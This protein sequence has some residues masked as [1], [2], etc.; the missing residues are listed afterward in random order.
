MKIAISTDGD[1]VSPHFG[2]CPSFTIIE[3]EN[4]EVV[5]KEIIENPGHHPGFIPEFLHKIG[6]NC[7]VCGGM[8]PRAQQICSQIGITSIVGITGKIQD[9]IE[10]I[11]KGTLQS[12][13]SL[14]NPGSGKNY[15]IEKS[16][17]NHDEKKETKK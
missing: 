11:K 10:E 17:C 9:V 7:I 4:G 6:V 1:Q 12:G 13:A 15:G 5:K 14:C 3:I 2:R 16:E 8:G